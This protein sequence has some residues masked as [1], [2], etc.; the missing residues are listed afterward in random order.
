MW[1][2]CNSIENPRGYKEEDLGRHFP[3]DFTAEGK[4]LP[5]RESD[6]PGESGEVVLD[7]VTYKFVG[8]QGEQDMDKCALKA[9]M[10]T[11]NFPEVAKGNNN[12]IKSLETRQNTAVKEESAQIDQLKADLQ[13]KGKALKSHLEGSAL[14]KAKLA[15]MNELLEQQIKACR[16]R[17]ADAKRQAEEI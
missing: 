12:L 9:A 1:Q 14:Q 2:I 3:A 6:G 16:A 5:N 8:R 15:K 17:E 10:Y 11:A 13:A 7:G 4:L